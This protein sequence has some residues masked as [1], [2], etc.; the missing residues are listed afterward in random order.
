MPSGNASSEVTPA[1]RSNALRRTPV[2][3]PLLTPAAPQLKP[4]VC[5]I[6]FCSFRRLPQQT[7]VTGRECVGSATM[8][9]ILS[10]TRDGTKP[11]RYTTWSS[12]AILGG[13]PWLRTKCNDV[14]VINPL[15]NSCLS[16]ASQLNGWRPVRRIKLA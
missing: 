1:R 5:F 9:F 16:G 4:L 14:G 8:S 12:H 13:A 15:S 3:T 10:C 6:I 11:P 2:H 7:S